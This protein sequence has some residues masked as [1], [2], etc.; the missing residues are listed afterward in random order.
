MKHTNYIEKVMRNA[1]AY[2]LGLDDIAC[3][4]EA[5]STEYQHV[6]RRVTMEGSDAC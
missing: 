1:H 5:E 2:I 4:C 6:L 3:S